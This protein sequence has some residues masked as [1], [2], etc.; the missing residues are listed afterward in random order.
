[1][2]NIIFFLRRKTLL[3][4]N[5]I[6]RKMNLKI[7]YRYSFGKPLNLKNP[8]TLAEKIQWLKLYEYTKP[9][10]TQCADK[11]LVRQYVRDQNCEEILIPLL[12]VYKT[13]SDIKWDNLPDS[14]VLKYNYGS[15]MNLFCR[16]KSLI[17]KEK[18]LE[19]VKKW[20]KV[21]CHSA[22]SEMHYAKI[23][24]L[25]LCEHLLQSK[26]GNRPADYKLYCFNGK[27][28]YLLL[29]VGR[30]YGN[31]K[32]YFFDRSWN[33]VRI[34]RN[35]IEA[36]ENFIL[37]KPSGIDK[38]W[39]YAEQLSKPFPFVRADFYLIDGN[40]F[41]GELTFTPSGGFD[42]ARLPE[43]DLLFGNHLILPKLN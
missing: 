9:I 3:L 31:P 13:A 2:G 28:L 5:K 23:E 16:D 15:G 4:L 39:R 41:F 21:D 35:S 14:F 29:C 33:L 18:T 25:I 24:K 30:E 40:V 38:V 36:P 37:D 27:P 42:S 20:S 43:T 19:T 7:H 10:Y 34:N 17:D 1:M 6:S 26:N 11:Y 32:F 22:C 12:G 8:Q